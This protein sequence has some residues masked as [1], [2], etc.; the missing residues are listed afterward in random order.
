M[1]HNRPSWLTG[2]SYAHRGLHQP[3][4]P[5][6]NSLPAFGAAIAAGHG[7]ECDVQQSR[8]AQAIVFHD[9]TLDR[10]TAET[11]AVRERTAA[12]LR[13]IALCEQSGHIPTLPEV[14]RLV[15]GRVPILVEIKSRRD[16]DWRPRFGIEDGYRDAYRWYQEEG[17]NTY[18][19]DFAAEDAVLAELG[20]TV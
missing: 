4:G 15:A 16:V 7:I 5:L 9:W 12:E 2:W 13:R 8:D 18:G 10:L 19:Y 6:E 20:R 14:L 1:P 3:G 17:R 11:G